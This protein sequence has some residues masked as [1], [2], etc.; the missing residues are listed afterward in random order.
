MTEQGIR[1]ALLFCAFCGTL[2]TLIGVVV[3]IVSRLTKFEVKID[4]HAAD[5]VEVRVEVREV[6]TEVRDLGSSLAA[7]DKNV[8]VNQ[9]RSPSG[10]ELS[11]LP[12]GKPR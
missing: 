9:A 7:L 2:A 3:Y 8:A 5:L 11:V 12:G 10:H 1:L 4:L 6:R